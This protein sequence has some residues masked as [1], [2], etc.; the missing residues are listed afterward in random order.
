MSACIYTLPDTVHYKIK[1]KT[2]VLRFHVMVDI[3]NE[4]VEITK[5]SHSRDTLVFPL[6]LLEEISSIF[7]DTNR[8]ISLKPEPDE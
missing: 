1:D 4:T 3:P 2:G 8:I 5:N 7:S 6:H